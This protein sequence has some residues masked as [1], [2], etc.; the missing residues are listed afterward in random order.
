MQVT[1]IYVYLYFVSRMD[2]M[3][4]KWKQFK[5]WK[6]TYLRALFMIVFHCEG[7]KPCLNFILWE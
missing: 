4:Y 1:E 2:L 7:G 3:Y 6:Y 5:T